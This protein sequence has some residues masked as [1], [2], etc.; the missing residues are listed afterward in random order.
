MLQPSPLSYSDIRLKA[1]SIG[2]VEEIYNKF[3]KAD[4]NLLLAKLGG[5]VTIVDNEPRFVEIT[6][7]NNFTVYLNPM[8][9]SL[10]TSLQ[11]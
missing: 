2:E 3:G 5:I 7:A 8:R 4:V 11:P 1:I 9:R 10:S 6:K